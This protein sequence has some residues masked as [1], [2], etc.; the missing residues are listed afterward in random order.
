M[1][2]DL[3]FH[4]GMYWHIYVHIGLYELYE[5]IYLHHL[6]ISISIAGEAAHFEVQF[7][8]KPGLVVWLKDNNPLDDRL[9]DRVIQTEATMNSYRLDIKNCRWIWMFALPYFQ[10]KVMITHWFIAY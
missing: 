9:A 1:R 8:E 5:N 6:L 4:R 2:K 7:A 3:K 10:T